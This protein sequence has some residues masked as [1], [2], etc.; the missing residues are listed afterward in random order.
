MRNDHKRCEPVRG[1]NP[2]GTREVAQVADVAH[3]N[4]APV[5]VVEGWVGVVEQFDRSN[6]SITFKVRGRTPVTN[7]VSGIVGDAGTVFPFE[8]NPELVKLLPLKS[9][10]KAIML[11]SLVVIRRK[12]KEQ[13]RK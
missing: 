7:P 6:G 2:R 3:K 10:N 11:S 1:E 8:P 4:E 9:L 13:F 12:A 5:P